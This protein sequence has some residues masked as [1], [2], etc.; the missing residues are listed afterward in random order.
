[1]SWK[2][3]PATDLRVHRSC[4]RLRSLYFRS[5][6]TWPEIHCA[7]AQALASVATLAMCGELVFHWCS[8]GTASVA[9]LAELTPRRWP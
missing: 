7:V 5:G 6:L 8:L 9:V 3:R 2:Y 1:M 4:F